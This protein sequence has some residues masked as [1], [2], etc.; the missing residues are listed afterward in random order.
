MRKETIMFRLT[1]AIALIL[2]GPA[3][4]AAASDGEVTASAPSAAW[5]QW[6]GIHRDAISPETGLLDRWDADGPRVVWRTTVGHGFS[7]VSIAGDRLYTMWDEKGR[8]L[9]VCLDAATGEERWR[10]EV[11]PAF[12]H[13]YGDGP[14]STPLVDSVTVFAVGTNGRLVALDRNTGALRWEHDLVKE[15]RAKLPT[16]GYSTSPLVLGDR[17]FLEVGGPSAAFVAF[18]KTS[19]DVLWATASDTSAY[20]S[21]LAVSIGGEPQIVFWS[22]HGLRALSPDDGRLLWRHDTESLCPVTGDPLNTG[23]PI[24][25]APDR[26]FVASGSGAALLRV[27]RTGER[28]G[29]TTVWESEQLRSDVNT[30]LYWNGQVYGFDRGTLKCLDAETGEVC[31]RARGFQRGSLIAADGKLFVLGESGELALAEATGAG[32]TVKGRSKIL[33]GRSWTAPSLAAG[34]LYLRNHEELVCLDVSG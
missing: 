28:Y 11:G 24:F 7:S 31:W 17:L 3:D 25:V 21:P 27:T 20:S 16:Y 26:V 34:R 30:A 9:L 8:Q 1:L 13:H 2:L 19:G 14:R 5:P 18:D 33:S 23:T 6:R 22:A 32:F 29:V 10:F 12:K 15:Y 4:V